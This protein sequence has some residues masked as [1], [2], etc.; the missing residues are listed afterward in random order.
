MKSKTAFVLILI[1]TSSILVDILFMELNGSVPPYVPFIK[2]IILI[3]ASVSCMFL[4]SPFTYLKLSAILLTINL[5][6][7]FIDY[8]KSTA[9]W[10]MALNMESS[11]Y[12]IG[13]TILLKLIGIIPVLIILFLMS[14]SKGD[15]YLC[16][17]D[18]STKADKISWLGVDKDSISWG[19]LSLISD[20]L[21]SIGTII[22]TITTVT[23]FSLPKRID[24]L[25]VYLP[26]ITLFALLNSFCEGIIFRN[27]ILGTLRD[28]L[29]KKYV[30]LIAAIFFGIGHYYGAP[31]GIIGIIMSSLL[32]WYMCTSMY[33]TNGLVSSRIIHFM[34]DVVIFSLLVSI[35][36]IYN[37]VL[38]YPQ[39]DILQAQV[40]QHAQSPFQETIPG[41]LLTTHL[42]LHEESVPLSYKKFVPYHL[43]TPWI[44]QANFVCYL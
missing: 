8:I 27:A 6:Q 29:P 24:K 30:V 9:L 34:Q 2:L 16:S 14:K 12:N 17:R 3:A 4:K 37:P 13:S 35:L 43:Q 44:C 26:I 11:V 38:K 19:K 23:G 40:H 10:E 25:Y 18:L 22:L 33:E 5:S 41:R 32:G 42:L 21:I 1:L 7:I 39:E 15:F 20:L 31:S 28:A 36:R